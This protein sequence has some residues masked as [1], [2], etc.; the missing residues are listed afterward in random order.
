MQH[1]VL[2]LLRPLHQLYC[3]VLLLL[4]LGQQLVQAELH[5]LREVQRVSVSSFR[6]L[7]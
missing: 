3:V 2:H 4:L 5:L 6:P 7:L 1:R